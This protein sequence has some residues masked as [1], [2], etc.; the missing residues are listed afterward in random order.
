MM[1]FQSFWKIRRRLEACGDELAGALTALKNHR[2]PEAKPSIHT[3]VLWLAAF[4]RY[5]LQGLN[6][7]TDY[8]RYHD[9]EDKKFIREILTDTQ[10]YNRLYD[11]SKVNLDTTASLDRANFVLRYRRLPSWYIKMLG[12]KMKHGID[13]LFEHTP[14][15]N[16]E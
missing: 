16:K 3:L 15:T 6:V 13:A 2:A 10:I 9:P 8:D 14:K 7:L 4:N 11:T 1:Y 5:S 12:V